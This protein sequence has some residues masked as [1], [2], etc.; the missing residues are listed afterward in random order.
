M[1]QHK[2]NLG[3]FRQRE[4]AGQERLHK[5]HFHEMSGRKSIKTKRKCSGSLGGCRDLG[6][7]GVISKWHRF[8]FEMMKVL[9]FFLI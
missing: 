1:S 4:R 6:Q 3:N 9:F 8:P 5:F 2:M 7:P